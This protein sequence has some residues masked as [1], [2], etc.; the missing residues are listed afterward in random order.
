ML[1]ALALVAGVAAGSGARAAVSLEYAIKANYLYK[2]G[3]FV[4]WPPGAFVGPA[5]P[6]NV[7]VVGEDPF[8]PA[9]D[10]ATKGQTVDGHPVTVRRLAVVSANPD[11]HVL[12]IGRAGA[13]KPAQILQL[14]HG[15]PVLTVTDDG[16]EG[17]V[18]RF[19]LRDGKVRFGVDATAAQA[20]G[21]VISSKLL[22]L[23]TPI[24]KAGG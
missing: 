15:Q 7:C 12:Y 9:L 5:S 13:Q 8:G 17:G 2:F 11:C 23:A 16:V 10:D 14:L 20:D 4:V 21:L 6:F 18:I 22:S 3:P 1:L 24:G 19:V